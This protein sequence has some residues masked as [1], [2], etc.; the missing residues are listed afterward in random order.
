MAYSL[1]NFATYGRFSLS[2]PKGFSLI[3]DVSIAADG[4]FMGGQIHSVKLVNGGMPT[5]DRGEQALELMRELAVD[6]PST[7]AT[8]EADGLIH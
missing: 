6:F 7:A 4:T 5:P 1:G 3:L 8:I 2:G